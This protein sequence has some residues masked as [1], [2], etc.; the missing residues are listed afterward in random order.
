MDGVTIIIIKCESIL[1]TPTLTR[2]IKC[3][4]YMFCVTVNSRL[5]TCNISTF[6]PTDTN[7]LG[8][9]LHSLFFIR[10]NGILIFWHRHKFFGNES[11]ESQYILIQYINVEIPTTMLSLCIYIF[12]ISVNV[13]ALNPSSGHI[14]INWRK[15]RYNIAMTTPTTSARPT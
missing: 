15:W 10:N 8:T 4:K 11:T 7:L 13:S 3:S 6:S 5:K 1:P 14:K 9:D 2:E 12:Y